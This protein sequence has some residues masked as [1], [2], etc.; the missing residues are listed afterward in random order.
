MHVYGV[1]SLLLANS[2][3]QTLTPQSQVGT[4]E[5]VHLGMV[6]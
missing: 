2:P 3:P 4:R 5:Y 1:A 6:V